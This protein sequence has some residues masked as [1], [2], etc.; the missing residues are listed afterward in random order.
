[1]PPG[2]ITT[3]EVVELPTIVA[4]EGLLTKLQEYVGEVPSVVTV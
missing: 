4:P 2:F 3:E 1:M